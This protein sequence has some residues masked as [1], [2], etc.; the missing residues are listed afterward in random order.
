MSNL[1]TEWQALG[2]LIGLALQVAAIIGFVYVA[3]IGLTLVTG[4]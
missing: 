4:F 3:V 2:K 1:K